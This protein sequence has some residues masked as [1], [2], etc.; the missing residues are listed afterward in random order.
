VSAASTSTHGSTASFANMND[1]NFSAGFR[2]NRRVCNEVNRFTV[3]A[4]AVLLPVAIA[5]F[6]IGCAA[7]VRP[8]QN[9]VPVRCCSSG[10]CEAGTPQA[11]GAKGFQRG[12]C[13]AHLSK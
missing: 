10:V 12:R 13:S 7:R 11:G 6:A 1:A 3:A 8:I 9:T 5:F 2:P 4:L